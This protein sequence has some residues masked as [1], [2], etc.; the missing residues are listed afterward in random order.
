MSIASTRRVSTSLSY[1]QPLNGGADVAK[2]NQSF[3]VK[4]QMREV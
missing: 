1:A 4:E 2:K 3:V